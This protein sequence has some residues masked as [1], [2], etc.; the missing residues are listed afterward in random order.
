MLL[1]ANRITGVNWVGLKTLIYREIARF[2]SVATQTL[3]GP[4]VT[5]ILYF[6]I[7]SVSIGNQHMPV[8]GIPY[9][10]FLGPG[11]IMMTMV[12][13]AFA[14]TSSSLVIAKIQGSI[15]DVLLPPL[16]ALELLVG[17]VVGGLVRGLMVGVVCT[18]AVMFF[19]HMPFPHL[20]LLL[21]FAVLGN[22]MMAVSGVI[23]GLWA[24][25]FDQIAAITN[26]IVTPLTFLSGTFYAVGQLPPFWQRVA[27]FNPFHHMIDGYRAAYTGVFETDLL[28]ALVSLIGCNIVLFIIAW[29]MLYTG[30]RTKT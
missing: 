13:N 16:S 6:M 22:M 23:G 3:I 2:M 19:V 14:N 24:Q 29:R 20:G 11:L 12:Q 27:Y 26:F 18:L 4:T 7:F 10:I 8:P 25:K 28:L 1:I 9:L 5:L 21:G 17:F 15:V 30:Y